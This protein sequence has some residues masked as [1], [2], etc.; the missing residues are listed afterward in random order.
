MTK[1]IHKILK[2]Q[3]IK[4]EKND[5]VVLYTD[6]ITECLNRREKDGNEVM[7]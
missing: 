7:F 2:E 4:F 3:E 5:I 6:G 1:N